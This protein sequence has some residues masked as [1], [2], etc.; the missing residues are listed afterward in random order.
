MTGLDIFRRLKAFYEQDKWFFVG[1]LGFLALSTAIGLVQPY[2]VKYL[3]DDIITPV[4][5]ELVGPLALSIVGVVVVKA[6]FQ[7]LHG[8]CRRRIRNRSAT[9][10]RNK[11]YEKFNEL[12]FQ[13]YDRAIT[14]DFMSRLT[15][16][17]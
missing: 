10:M 8:F 14:R 1:A 11:L 9:K 7:F 12:S 16:D 5:Y 6:F 2:L 4:N 3:I 15:A 13:Y 17:L